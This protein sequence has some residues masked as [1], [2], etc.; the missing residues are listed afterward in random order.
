MPL[1]KKPQNDSLIEYINTKNNYPVFLECAELTTDPYWIQIFQECSKGKFPKGSGIDAIG[2]TIYFKNKINN[3]NFITYKVSN[4]P[5][6]VFN[7][8]KKIFLSKLNIKS[9]KD[10]EN[11]QDEIVDI[12]KDLQESYNGQWQQI[13]K[14]KIKDPIIRRFILDLKERYNLENKETAQVAQIIKL[15]FLFNWITNDQVI[16]EN[17]QIIDITS[18]HYIEEDRIFTLDEPDVDYKREYKPKLNNLGN[19]WLKHLKKPK[20]VYLL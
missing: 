17:Q 2:S 10:R 9:N 11:T 14:K 20:N 15:G 8:L 4:D 19:L 18:L 6:Q 1:E 16:Y 12:C 3:K 7:D 5:E 13:K